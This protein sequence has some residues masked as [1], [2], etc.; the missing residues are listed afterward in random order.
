MLCFGMSLLRRLGQMCQLKLTFGFCD[1]W[2]GMRYPVAVEGRR[3]RLTARG[4]GG[5]GGVTRIFDWPTGS[6][7]LCAPRGV[8]FPGERRERRHSGADH[9][10]LRRGPPR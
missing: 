2:I 1:N 10:L 7:I 6:R 4:W 8:G 9:A 3:L 5:G